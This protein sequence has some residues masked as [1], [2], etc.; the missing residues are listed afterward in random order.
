M[1]D[2]SSVGVVAEQRREGPPPFAVPFGQELVGGSKTAR[3]GPIERRQ[4]DR[5]VVAVGV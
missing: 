3:D 4:I 2:D 1:P 5:L